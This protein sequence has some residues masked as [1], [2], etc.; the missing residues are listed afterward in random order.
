LSLTKTVAH[1]ARRLI[2]GR[3]SAGTPE[4][5]VLQFLSNSPAL[6]RE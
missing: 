4:M 2:E 6:S 3:F 5:I 1:L